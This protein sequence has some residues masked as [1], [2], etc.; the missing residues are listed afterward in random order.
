MQLV[1]AVVI[2]TKS[3]SPKSMLFLLFQLNL[4]LHRCLHFI[5][6]N[7]NKKYCFLKRHIWGCVHMGVGVG[8]NVLQMSVVLRAL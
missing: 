3:T 8:V 7:N 2:R 6:R 4:F 1:K 5:Q